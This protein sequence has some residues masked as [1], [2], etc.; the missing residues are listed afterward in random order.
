MD[1]YVSIE[2]EAE[3]RAKNAE[4]G[5]PIPLQSDPLKLL[6]EYPFQALPESLAKAAEE[7]ARF[8]KV[9]PESPASIA[10]S[11]VATAIG[12]NAVVVER[13]G[14][15]HFPALFFTLIAA[16]GE[17]KSPPF[18]KL[19]YP[20]IQ[21]IEQQAEAYQFA[22]DEA[23]A[24]NA[25]VESRI[26]KLTKEAEKSETALERQD[27]ARQIANIKTEK[28]P[29]PLHPR[30]F[31][32]DYTEQVLF[33]LMEH[34]NGEYSIQSGE[35]RP[36]IDSILGKYS[37]DGK[38]GDGVILA[39]ISG[40][41]IT[42]D[43]I[44]SAETGGQE[45][46]VILNPCLNVCVMVQPDKY[47]Q[48]ARHPSLRASGALARIFPVW[49]PCLV[50]TRLEEKDEPDLSRAALGQYNVLIMQLLNTQRDEPHRAT[51]S[52]EAAELRRQYHNSIEIMMA[53]GGDYDDVRDIASKAV[54]QT[55]KLALVLHV[56]M[57]PSALEN[58]VSE[59][60]PETFNKAMALGF[61]HLS[62]AVASQ[63]AA[64]EETTLAPARRILEWMQREHAKKG[65][66][67]FSFADLL[68][69]SSRPRPKANELMTIMETLQTHRWVIAIDS[70]NKHPDYILQRANNGK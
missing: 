17:R 5:E 62:Q 66:S 31:T 49:L 52:P 54:S 69:K 11:M 45:S 30:K 15:D 12:K 70:K 41:T 26:R 8:D 10:L 38:T 63:R 28:A 35:G 7:I 22:K 21:Y 46:G 55:V 34:N 4:T 19:Q 25:V 58:D 27:I 50:G 53:A 40:D 14:L 64:D 9:P 2:K 3:T 18:K 33:R 13:D 20:F 39:G 43:R 51:L 24:I 68:Q 47:Q 61:Y 42:R 23:E 59:I 37:G 1:E 57:N 32:S 16:S 29:L 67:V 65:T 44:G 56:A 48:A 60:S 6:P 36:V